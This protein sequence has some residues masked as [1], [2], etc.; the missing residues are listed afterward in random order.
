MVEELRETPILGV[1]LEY[2]DAVNSMQGLKN[3]IFSESNGFGILGMMQ[4]STTKSDYLIDCFTLRDYARQ[5]DS[6]ISLKAVFSD[7]KVTKIMHSGD[8]DLKYLISDFGIVTVNMFDTAHAFQFLQRI[9]KLCDIQE[10]GQFQTTK[11]LNT[12]SLLNLT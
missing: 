11:N 2:F 1:D 12:I 10:K 9:P 3:H 7:E 6:I 8:S 5:D 4:L